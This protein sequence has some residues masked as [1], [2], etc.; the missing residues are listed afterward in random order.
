MTDTKEQERNPRIALSRPGP[1][2]E[3]KTTVD[4]GVV[5]Q[6]FSHGRSMAVA[7]AV[8]RKRNIKPG[9]AGRAESVVPGPAGRAAEA[10][11]GTRAAV[12]AGRGL[13][14]RPVVLKP[15]AD[16]E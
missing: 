7:V 2:L 11:P 14:R 5:R 15:L 10:A 8:K 6:S 13:T 1:R 4:S 12:E 3:L 9:A 16:E